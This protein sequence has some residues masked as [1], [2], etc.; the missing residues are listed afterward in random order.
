MSWRMILAA[1]L[2]GVALCGACANDAELLYE[3]ELG[4]GGADVPPPVT[5]GF[6][7]GSGGF[8]F[9]TGSGGE[10]PPPAS[11]PPP[12][13]PVCECEAFGYCFCE[14]TPEPG[15]CSMFCPDGYCG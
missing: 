15:H 14:P 3:R 2:G 4:G 8:L 9:P 10:P 11:C 5:G 13:E 12:G 1:I 6:T 7:A